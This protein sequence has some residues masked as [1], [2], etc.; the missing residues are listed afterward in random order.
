MI[1]S[2]HRDVDGTCRGYS[3]RQVAV[4]REISHDKWDRWEGSWGPVHAGHV[5][6]GSLDATLGAG[7]PGAE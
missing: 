1:E 6:A 4:G 5:D 2:L 3:Q 7:T